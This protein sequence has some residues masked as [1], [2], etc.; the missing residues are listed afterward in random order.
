[1]SKKL[2]MPY[3]AESEDKVVDTMY[4]LKNKLKQ[5]EKNLQD[6]I[7]KM[8]PKELRVI[9]TLSGRE[10]TGKVSGVCWSGRVTVLNEKTGKSRQFDPT[11]E[12]WKLA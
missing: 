2:V 3:G 12:R 5:A 10:I 9:V 6:H 1:M 7:I 11:M 4:E 8:F